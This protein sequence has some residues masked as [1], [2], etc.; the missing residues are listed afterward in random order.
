MHLNTNHFRTHFH[1]LEAHVS[2]NPDESHS[3][4][5]LEG[6][7]FYRSNR[8]GQHQSAIDK[9]IIVQIYL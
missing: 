2:E 3:I 8:V 1:I 9:I 7:N 4:L 5:S 6:F